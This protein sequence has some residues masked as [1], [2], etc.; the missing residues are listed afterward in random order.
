MKLIRL[1][2]KHSGEPWT[3]NA[4]HILLIV[5]QA[6]GGC[7]LWFRGDDGYEFFVQESQH[8]IEFLMTN[9]E[10]ERRNVDLGDEYKICHPNPYAPART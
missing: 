7:S 2:E 10:P 8:F 1:R 4:D 9:E 5:P 3:F 6:A